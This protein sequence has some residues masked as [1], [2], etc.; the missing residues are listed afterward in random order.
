MELI[1]L[2]DFQWGG[3]ITEEGIYKRDIN[4]IGNLRR[5]VFFSSFLASF[6]GKSVVNVS[7]IK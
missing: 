1:I 2:L 5:C 6:A 4:S 3:R 7:H